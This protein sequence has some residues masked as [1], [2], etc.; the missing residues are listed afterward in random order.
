MRATIYEKAAKVNAMFWV[1]EMKK[2]KEMLT[3]Y[4]A[5]CLLKQFSLISRYIWYGNAESCS[6][7]IFGLA[8]M[9]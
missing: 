8:S 2:K 4:S 7:H 1:S 5:S 3:E 6:V 9:G